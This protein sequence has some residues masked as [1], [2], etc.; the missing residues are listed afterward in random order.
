M[1]KHNQNHRMQRMQGLI[2]ELVSYT[3]LVNIKEAL[4]KLNLNS[5][6]DAVKKSL[7]ELIVSKKVSIYSTELPFINGYN[8]QLNLL[9]YHIIFNA[10]KFSIEGVDPVLRITY[11]IIERNRM[12][13]VDRNLLNEDYLQISISD[14]GIGF[15]NEFAIKIFNIFQRL[16]TQS[17]NYEGKGI[18][19]AIC[20]RVMF[21]HNGIITAEGI[22]DGGATFYLYF[23]ASLVT[24]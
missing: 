11:A 5:I 13:V 12:S 15:E 24:H 14:N 8:K 10:I 23:P 1:V 20:R 21:N 9:F 17:S 7:S 16:H 3:G 19:L 22:R 18:G 6:I 4:Q 2:E